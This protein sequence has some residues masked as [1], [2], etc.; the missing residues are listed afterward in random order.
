MLAAFVLLSAALCP[1]GGHAACSAPAG[2]DGDFIFNTSSHV[3]Q[4]CDGTNWNAMGKLP[5]TGGSGC[6]GPAGLEGDFVYSISSHVPQYCDGA[7]W[8][9]IGRVPGAGGA[10]CSN[11]AAGEG[12]LI[13]NSAYSVPQYCDGANWVAVGKIPTISPFSFTE[14][15][16]VPTNSSITSDAVILGGGLKNVTAAC[17][18]GCTAISINGGAFTAGPVPGV[19]SGDTIAI[20]QTSSAS[21]N[22]YTSASV[23]VG[24][25]TSSPWRVKTATVDPFSFID[26]NPGSGS[27]AVSNT[28][29]LTGGFQNKTATCNAGCTGISINGGAFAAG[30]VNGV[31]SGDTIAIRQTPAAEVC[32]GGGSSGATTTASVSVGGTTSGVWSVTTPAAIQTF[33]AN[34][35]WTKLSTCSSTTTVRAQCWGGGGGGAGGPG[36]R[37]GGGGGGGGYSYTAGVLGDYTD[38]VPVVV[39]AGG[40]GGGTGADGGDGGDSSFGGVLAGGGNSGISNGPGGTGG[41]G[42]YS[43]G[44]GGTQNNNSFGGGGGGA[45]NLSGNG[46][47]GAISVS[48]G[49][50]G[51]PAG[52]GGGVG[53]AGGT[54][55][56]NTALAAAGGSYGGG[57]GGGSGYG[58]K[59][60][61]AGGGGICV[62]TTDGSLP[63]TSLFFSSQ[64]GVALDSTITSETK[65]LGGGLTNVTATCNAGCTGISRNGG[66]FVPGPVSGFNTGDTIAIQQVSSTT[67]NITSTATVTVGSITSSTWTVTT[68][69]VNAFNFT[70]QARVNINSTITSNAVVLGGG[71]ANATAVCG[72]NCTAISINGGAFVAGPVYGVNNGDTIAIQQTSSGSGNTGTTARVAVG[73]RI[74]TNWGV[75]TFGAFADLLGVSVSSATTSNTLALGAGFSGVT[76]TC[77][78]GCTGIS[79]NGAAM[80]AGPVS[81]VNSGDTIAI[82]QTSSASGNTTTTAVVTVGMV[83]SV[84]W[85]IT[86]GFTGSHTFTYTGAL[87]YYVVTSGCTSITA[88]L[89]GGGGGG[90]N[91]DNG[92]TPGTGTGGAGGAGGYATGVISGLTVGETLTITVGA[93]GTGSSSGSG[94]FGGGGGTYQYSAAGKGGGRS[95][96]NG[97]ATIFTAAGGGGGAGADTGR[98][99]GVGGSGGGTTG[100]N[101]V[102]GTTVATGGTQAAGGSRGTGSD[103]GT[104]GSLSQGGTGGGYSGDVDSGGGGGGGYY[105]G[106]GGAGMSGAV[107]GGG[108]GGSSY[109]GGGGYS[110]SATNTIAGNGG[111]GGAGATGSTEGG[112]GGNG[113]VAITCP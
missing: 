47:N 12:R 43:G 51:G 89:T 88:T 63:M 84:A 57:G 13:Y 106:G 92:G 62:I 27:P 75:T 52:T 3:P 72:T 107:G 23:T 21:E 61:G 10:G 40:L 39:G 35:T 30:P 11:P 87:Q 113:Q 29:T 59:L 31:N 24:P 42:I 49:A 73:G 46:S 74:S 54:G 97:T 76:V 94:V 101:G 98:T 28:V 25:A 22:T 110:V 81:N 50:M 14:Q 2:G 44:S 64:T 38:T 85:S 45:A 5:G 79:I 65:M 103:L 102:G 78:A 69:I 105:G 18:S 99:G 86:T 6:S 9:P 95:A 48:T 67:Y 70:N 37:G 104:N 58:A 112:T 80:T 56:S 20:R 16:G 53:G 109:V 77:G 19:N 83:T 90:G 8:R 17:N 60:G 4:Y 26:L 41:T 96:V 91:S 108:A 1:A 32:M 82:R 34:G 36:S 93:G 71:F 55:G 66:A 111:A 68:G 100:S 7:S 15:T 33:T